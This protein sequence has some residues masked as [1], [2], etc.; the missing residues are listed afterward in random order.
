MRA[1]SSSQILFFTQLIPELFR[2]PISCQFILSC[3]SA[4]DPPRN[5]ETFGSQMPLCSLSRLLWSPFESAGRRPKD[6][7][8]RVGAGQLVRRGLALCALGQPCL[9]PTPPPRLFR[10]CL[11]EAGLGAGYRPLGD[12]VLHLKVGA[13]RE[14]D[15]ASEGMSVPTGPQMWL[16]ALFRKAFNEEQWRRP[17]PPH[18][19]QKTFALDQVSRSKP[20]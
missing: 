16:L 19:P 5:Y 13:G 1:P 11:L 3:H 2:D 18:T 17:V 4:G 12:T 6:R 9:N 10:G 14:C 15:G 8:W 7:A 20:R